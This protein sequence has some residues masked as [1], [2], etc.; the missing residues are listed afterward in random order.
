MTFM[1]RNI[2]FVFALAVSLGHLFA[3]G[4]VSGRVV[5]AKNGHPVEY[6]SVALLRAT[7]SSLVG[8]DV[9][10]SNG[11][12]EVKVGYGTYLMRIS[13]M[14]YD[15][16][17]HTATL[18]LSAA[19]ASINV[20]KVEMR[21][22]GT[23]MDEVVVTAER[24]MMEYQ[25]DKRVINVDKNLVTSGGT[26]TE[27]L[28]NVPSVSIDNDGTVSLRG[29][30]NVKVLI[31]GRPY[32]LM[33]NDLET[34]LEQIPA[35]SV[36]NVEVITNP[37]A[38]YDPEGMSGIIN[39][40]LKDNA[41]NALGMN[42]VATVNM[43]T[44]LAFLGSDYPS[45]LPS[46]VPTLMGSLNLNYSTEK[47]NIFFTADGG[48]RGRGHRGETDIERL[49]NGTTL[50]H[51]SVWQYS[52]NRNTMASA[53]IGGEYYLSKRSSLMASYQ[54][55]YGNW[56]REGIIRSHDLHTAGYLDY[57]QVDTS[58]NR[59]NNHV[60]NVNFTQKFDNPDQLLTVNAT[61]SM[62]NM[63]GNGRQQQLYNGAAVWANDYVRE[64]K[65][66]NHH[67]ELN[68][69]LN[70]THPFASAWKFETGYEG[71]M[72]WPDQDAT[73]YRTEYDTTTHNLFTFFDATSSTHFKY[74][75]QV[76][77][78]FATLGG[79][80]GER[81]SV[82]AGLRGEYASMLGYDV[83]HPSADSV[84]KV[85]WQLYPTLH[86]S[87]EINDRQS[88]QLSYSRRVRRPHMWDLNPYLDVREG[89]QMSFGNPNLDPEYTNA[90][91]L[92]YN[93]GVNKLNVFSS[94]YLR[95]TNNMMT[96]YGFVWDSLSRNRYSWWMP[97]S[98]EYDGYWAST[99]Q[100]LNN[101]YNYG[102]E[103]IVDYQVAGWWKLNISVNLY[104]STIEGTAL[105]DNKDKSAFMCSGKFNSYMTLPHDWTIQLSGQ[106]WAPHLDLQTEMFASY[107]V[108]LAVKK[109][110]WQKRASLNL[111]VGDIFCT[112][113]WGHETHT[114]QLN[115][116]THS[117][118][119]S[120]T[121]SLGFTYK[122]NNGLR[123]RNGNNADV[124]MEIEGDS[125][126]TWH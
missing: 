44:P 35:S 118:R 117:H 29:S 43:G 70:Y 69:Q 20:G 80:I 90:F 40:K 116:T 5:D 34:L 92:S 47:Y 95:Q 59:N 119:L 93:V 10:L 62:R 123:Q 67:H 48:M 61:L 41:S 36:E 88:F 96:R 74:N 124:E 18:S 14:G 89:Q 19:H 65:T 9:T 51:D 84:S 91:E 37:S 38:K 54:F 81:F 15:T 99:W 4:T 120:P 72:S 101:G 53:K 75:Q 114:A 98:S 32:E 126:A 11:K 30:S 16:Y 105:L 121:V 7:D 55:R 82:Q 110:I 13:F 8:G 79:K 77:A 64:S 23:M 17:F 26:A 122:I 45:E 108:D 73:Y 103:F 97:Y 86:L 27:V 1:K 46:I 6:A 111:R 63:S 33:G 85:Y 68:L 100:N 94:I 112:G 78:I 83:N 104:Q 57:T 21:Q 31:N 42:G 106:Y 50:S 76:H 52:V 87:Y 58:D 113:G 56:H 3:Q 39:L 49:N 60:F 102:M 28:Q 22:S 12:F 71:R 24:T 115:R 109:D 66:E 107:W 25:L 2:L 125:S